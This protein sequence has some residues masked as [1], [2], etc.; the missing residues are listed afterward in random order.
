VGYLDSGGQASHLL[1]CRMWTTAVVACMATGCGS[2]KNPSPADS[3]PGSPNDDTGEPEDTGM[4]EGLPGCAGGDELFA[5][6]REFME[7]EAADNDVPGLAVAV[8]CD[9]HLAYAAATGLVHHG[10]DEPMET[11]TRFQL[12]STTK[13]FTA[14][15]VLSMVDAG[16]LDLD[17]G[18]DAVVTEAPIGAPYDQVVTLHQLLSHTAGY[19]TWFPDGSFASY[20]L[21]R[22]FAN[23]ADQP[24]WSPPGTLYN[25]SNL[26][27]SLA[28]LVV[29]EADGRSFADAVQARVF[30]PAGMEGASMD[31]AEVESDGRF[32]YGHSGS[33]GA[34]T[35]YA[36]TDSYLPTGYYGPMGGAWGSVIDM[37]RW[38]EV[39]L[40]D[41]GDVLSADSAEALRTPHAETR[42]YPGQFY[43][44][45]L[46]VDTLR[47][48]ATVLSHSGSV[49]GYL[50]SWRL[51]PEQEF[52]VVALTNCDW[53][54][55]GYV[56]DRA[57]ELFADLA[58]PDLSDHAASSD[59]WPAYAGRYVDPY[60]LGE[61]EVTQVGTTLQADFGDQGFSSELFGSYLDNY[62]F[63]YSPA[64]YW[65]T[66]TFWREPE[67]GD[68]AWMVTAHGVAARAD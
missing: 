28:G 49:A 23:N 41:G 58:D 38:G 19:P 53:Y 29:E 51:I 1:R 7:Q 4:E 46:Y 52:G 66:T 40:A 37:A 8:I 22:Y 5:Q 2:D 45:G 11:D 50:A 36:P 57:V 27:F 65:L 55:P 43:G 48:D 60:V 10:G 13:M 68:A 12:A 30:E 26:G 15:A 63:Y 14:A 20:E 33:A 54:W 24:L 9:G 39:H 62:Y 44:Y 67:D 6:L 31:A 42:R 18:V 34:P 21:D 59:D 61:V 35:V 56:G 25:Y 32:A 47:D 64:G 17:A 16:E 3:A